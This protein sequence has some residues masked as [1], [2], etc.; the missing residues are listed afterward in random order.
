MYPRTFGR[1]ERGAEAPHYPYKPDTSIGKPLQGFQIGG[2][3]LPMCAYTTF[4]VPTHIEVPQGL[5]SL[6]ENLF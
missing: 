6:C 2:K 5:K 3:I 4:V 1:D